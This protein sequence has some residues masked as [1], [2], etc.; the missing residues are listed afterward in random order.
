MRP[1][2]LREGTRVARGKPQPTRL[3]KASGPRDAHPPAGSGQWKSL[4][5]GC[6]RL[7]GG[8]SSAPGQEGLLRSSA[9]LRLCPRPAFMSP[10]CANAGPL[11]SRSLVY[12]HKLH[13]GFY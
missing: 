13:F 10:E 2:L 8:V 5:L 11:R 4:L 12:L 9:A 6:H 1:G 7:A 3:F